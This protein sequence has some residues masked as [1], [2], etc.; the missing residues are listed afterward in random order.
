MAGKR[1]GTCS[2]C[3]KGPRSINLKHPVTGQPICRT[4]YRHLTGKSKP[5][6]GTCPRCR[7]D[8]L[9]IRYIHPKTGDNICLLCRQTLIGNPTFRRGK[10]YRCR[11]WRYLLF[12]DPE[13]R[14]HICRSCFKKTRSLLGVW[15]LAEERRDAHSI[16]LPPQFSWWWNTFVNLKRL[17]EE[18]LNEAKLMLVGF[19]I[20]K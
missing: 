3:G 18:Y 19:W 11:K 15:H 4:C 6:R 13:T 17:I 16:N 9:D 2:H 5:K 1:V 8:D 14:F 12:V 7:E 20:K 10:C